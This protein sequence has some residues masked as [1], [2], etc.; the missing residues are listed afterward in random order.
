MTATSA[1][2]DWLEP[3]VI[4]PD[5]FEKA[6]NAL[7]RVNNGGGCESTFDPAACDETIALAKKAIAALEEC[8]TPNTPTSRPQKRGSLWRQKTGLARRK[9]LD[10]TCT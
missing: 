4:E 5:M 1:W 3:V 6:R 8:G 7:A 2:A 9:A 10:D